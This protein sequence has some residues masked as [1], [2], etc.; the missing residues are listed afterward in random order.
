MFFFLPKVCPDHAGELAALLSPYIAEFGRRRKGVGTQGK[1][2]GKGDQRK[3]GERADDRLT[4]W[5][6]NL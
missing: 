5:A 6:P 1:G 3:L 4:V 2:D